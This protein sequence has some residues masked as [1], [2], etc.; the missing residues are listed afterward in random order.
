MPGSQMNLKM[1]CTERV[2][3]AARLGEKKRP[4]GRGNR[5][6]WGSH[7]GDF[8]RPGDYNGPPVPDG[9][10]RGEGGGK[11][12]LRRGPLSSLNRKAMGKV[13]RDGEQ[14]DKKESLKE[15]GIIGSQG[16]GSSFRK[17]VNSKKGSIRT[18]KCIT[19][20]RRNEKGTV[21]ERAREKGGVC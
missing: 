17:R 4:S 8:R 10:R 13:E 20:F 2:K 11:L 15:Q 6:N 18:S 12:V 14:K 9:D 19:T 21:N 7:W 1:I 16:A 5:S 3:L